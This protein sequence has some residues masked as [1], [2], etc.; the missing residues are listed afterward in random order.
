VVKKIY[1]YLHST[2][3]TENMIRQEFYFYV[4]DEQGNEI[5]TA[6]RLCKQPSRTNEW[7]L[8]NQRVN[9]FQDLHTHGARTLFQH[10]KISFIKDKLTTKMLNNSIAYDR[11]RRMDKDSGVVYD[12]FGKVI[13]VE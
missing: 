3:Q 2:N 1:V 13:K 11:Y 4:I 12:C 10:E 7:L 6:K 8:N 5:F 9:K